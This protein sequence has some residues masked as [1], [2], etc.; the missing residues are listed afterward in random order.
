MARAE[1]AVAA[2]I[3]GCLRWHFSTDR[4]GA[5]LE[6]TYQESLIPVEDW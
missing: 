6:P 4:T 2:A 1:H 3:P 5:S